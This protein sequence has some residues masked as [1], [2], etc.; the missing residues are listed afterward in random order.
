MANVV[1]TVLYVED[2]EMDRFLM[3]RAF[4]K[5]GL[6]TNLQL[7]ND[8]RTA[9]DYLSGVGKYANREDYPFPSVVLL[10]LHL[11]EIHGFEVLKWIRAQ[12][13][14]ENLPVVIFSSSERAE[15]QAK[16]QQLGA[17]E[18][19]NKPGSGLSFLDV[20]RRLAQQWLTAPSVDRK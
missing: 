8:G 14:T 2:E 4:S 19:V 6:G 15:D 13:P 5:E 7:V 20:V 12:P 1:S 16:A 9:I 17:N 18:F 3:Q 11:P 10:D